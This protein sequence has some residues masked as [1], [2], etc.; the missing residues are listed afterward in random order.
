MA[1]GI[2]EIT[3]HLPGIQSLKEK[4]S[5]LERLKNSLRRQFNISVAETDERDKWQLSVLTIACVAG[6]GTLAHQM[7]ERVLS[8]LERDADVFVTHV[9]TEVL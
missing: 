5:V 6:S 4:R 1:V 8:V 2:A 3:L 7:V 9:N